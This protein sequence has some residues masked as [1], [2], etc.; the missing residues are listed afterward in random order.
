[1]WPGKAGWLRV[2]RGQMATP[3]MLQWLLFHLD[4]PQILLLMEG[5]VCM[6]PPL[7]VSETLSSRYW[8]MRHFSILLAFSWF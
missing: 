6:W 2:S 5:V 1:M 8:M 4:R 3:A 7:L